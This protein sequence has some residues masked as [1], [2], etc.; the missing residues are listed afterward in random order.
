MKYQ[1]TELRSMRFLSMGLAKQEVYRRKL[2]A[3]Y[4]LEQH[5]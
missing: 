1:Q 5:I 2:K 4:K 3:Y